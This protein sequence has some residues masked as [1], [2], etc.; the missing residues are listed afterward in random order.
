M[1]EDTL[2]LFP[3]RARQLVSSSSASALATGDFTISM[4]TGFT[5]PLGHWPGEVCSGAPVTL[6]AG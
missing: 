4:S 3:E 6:D 1:P 2:D 5:S